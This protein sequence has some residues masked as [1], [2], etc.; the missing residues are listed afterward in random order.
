MEPAWP[1]A[2]AVL[3]APSPASHAGGFPTA[4]SRSVGCVGPAGWA[5][6]RTHTG[7]D[8]SID[9]DCQEVAAPST[10]EL[11]SAKTTSLPPC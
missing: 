9:L 5:G 3:P 7:A 1:L 11:Q 6:P 10:R 8:G 2:A 4:S